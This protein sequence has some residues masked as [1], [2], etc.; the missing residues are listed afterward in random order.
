MSKSIQKI[1]FVGIGNIFN[2]VL[3]FAFISATAKTLDLDSFGKYALLATLLVAISKLIDF[4]TNS[5]YVAK[6][7]STENKSLLNT[8]YTLK[9]ILLL[10]SIPVSVITLLLFKLNSFQILLYFVLGLIAYSINYTLNPIFQKEEKFFY[11]ILLNTLPALIK[12]TFAI[13][14]FTRLVSLDLTQAFE[15]FSLSLLS[16]AFMV[17]FLPKEYKQFKFKISQTLNLIKESYP[18]GISQLIYE[19]WPSIANSIAKIAKDFSNVGIFSIAEKITNILTLASVSV[20]TVLLPKNA[21]RKKQ[22]L[23]YDFKEIIIISILIIAT[24][25]FGI[26]ASEIFITRFM[27]DKFSESIPLL[28]LLIFASAFT[29]IHTFMEHYFFIEEK[30]KYIMYINL[31]KLGVFLIL[32]AILT[33]ILSLQGLAI[34]NL[35]AALSA[36]SSTAIIIWKNQKKKIND[37]LT[38]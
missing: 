2:A 37:T 9:I 31:G 3:G 36:L 28:G 5:V 25:F 14:I 7:I 27:G 8:F 29:S 19:G 32:S 38:I 12:G 4:G 34:S 21:Y 18:A 13:L 22:K 20:F 24:A 17:L 10:V 11:F 6:S 16:S 15:V 23:G 26:F 35:V 30:I 1:M 33:P